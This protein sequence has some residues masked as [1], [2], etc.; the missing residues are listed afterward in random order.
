[1]EE[2]WTLHLGIGVRFSPYMKCG[3][4]EAAR[5]PWEKEI[6]EI[7]QDVVRGSSALPT[8]K[9]FAFMPPLALNQATNPGDISKLSH[10]EKAAFVDIHRRKSY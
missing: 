9:R 5:L 3:G 2:W 8:G 1:M 6:D 7:P 10:Q 4:W